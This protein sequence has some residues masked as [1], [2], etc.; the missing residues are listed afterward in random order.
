MRV[1]QPGVEGKH[2]HFNGKAKEEGEKDQILRRQTKKD[3]LRRDFEIINEFDD[4]KG[5]FARSIVWVTI[6]KVERQNPQQH[7]HRAKQSVQ[8]ELNGRIQAPPMAPNANE[9]VHRH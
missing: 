3:R 4:V 8:E 6:E 7:E 2:R 1:G 9:E 5:E